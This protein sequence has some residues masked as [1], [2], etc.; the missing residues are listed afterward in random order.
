MHAMQQQ[1]HNYVLTQK[2]IKSGKIK[3]VRMRYGVNEYTLHW[4]FKKRVVRES[5]K[6][7]QKMWNGNGI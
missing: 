4:K 3:L 1:E 5:V 7:K 6:N 2:L